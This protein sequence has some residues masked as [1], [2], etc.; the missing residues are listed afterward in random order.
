M[1]IV[2]VMKITPSIGRAYGT[3]TQV[4]IALIQTL[5]TYSKAAYAASLSTVVVLVKQVNLKNF[6]TCK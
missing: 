3:L 6:E 1:A 4:F 5:L 2:V